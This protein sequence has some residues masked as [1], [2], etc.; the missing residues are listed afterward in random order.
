MP[1]ELEIHLHTCRSLSVG[2][3]SG[4][5]RTDEPPSSGG[6]DS[7]GLDRSCELMLDREWREKGE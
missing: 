7:P 6:G 3:K 2:L 5:V 1:F 4:L